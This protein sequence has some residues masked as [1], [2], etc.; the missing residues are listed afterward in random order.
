MGCVKSTPLETSQ[1]SSYGPA[2]AED[3]STYYESESEPETVPP[4]PVSSID[5]K[6]QFYWTNS[7][8]E[9]DLPG[10]PCADPLD[11][12]SSGVTMKTS[13]KY[14]SMMEIPLDRCDGSAKLPESEY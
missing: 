5:G 6:V 9:T 2:Y 13:K 10:T 3:W 11:K 1:S 12:E 4:V 7:A 14:P 8:P